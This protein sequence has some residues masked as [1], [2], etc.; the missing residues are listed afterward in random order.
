MRPGEMVQGRKRRAVCA[1][2]AAAR[3][4]GRVGQSLRGHRLPRA[5]GSSEYAPAAQHEPLAAEEGAYADDVFAVVGKT[6]R[7]IDRRSL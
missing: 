1:C 4:T 7:Y 3:V 6:V 2:Q 5:E